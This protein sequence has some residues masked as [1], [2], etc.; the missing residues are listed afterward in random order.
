MLFITGG[1]T[2]IEGIA[3]GVQLHTGLPTAVASPFSSSGIQASAILQQQ[4]PLLLKACG[5]AVRGAG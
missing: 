3:D 4:S 5:L 1:C 2:R